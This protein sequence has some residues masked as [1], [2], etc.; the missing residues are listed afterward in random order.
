MS[1]S[2]AR[3]EELRRSDTLDLEFVD[4]M[5]LQHRGAIRMTHA[6][7]ADAPDAELRRFA[8][9]VLT[10]RRRELSQLTIVRDFQSATGARD[11]GDQ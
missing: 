4:A 1:H 8:G 10:A 5:I 6:V 3:V 9:E 2:H 7:L 11:D